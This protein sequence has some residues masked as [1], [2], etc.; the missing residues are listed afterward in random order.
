MKYVYS[1]TYTMPWSGSFGQIELMISED[2]SG[3]APHP[4]MEPGL[5]PGWIQQWEG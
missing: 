5:N 4:G 3:S 2:K 1:P